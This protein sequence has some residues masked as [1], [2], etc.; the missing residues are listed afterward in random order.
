MKF[1]LFEYCILFC[2]K[3][4]T[5]FCPMFPFSHTGKP[6]VQGYKMGTFTVGTPSP[7]IKGGEGIRPFQKLSHLGGGGGVQK[8]L[9]LLYSS[10]Q[11]H[12]LSV[13][14]CVCVCACVCVC[15]C[16]RGVSFPLYLSD[17]SLFR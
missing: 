1:F 16:V 7:L 14:V 13:C 11:L 8:F 5:H 12:L 3:P 9:L 17:L 15:V 10:V 2:V 6:L 4:L